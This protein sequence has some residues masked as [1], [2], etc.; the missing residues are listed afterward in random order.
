MTDFLHSLV[1]VGLGQSIV[2]QLD[3]AANVQVMNEA[4]FGRYRRGEAYRYRGGRQTLSPAV[5]PTPPGRWHVAIDLGGAT[6]RIAAS[7]SV[8]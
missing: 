5:I 6:G 2:V 8:Q 3:H 4:E 7:V 1:T